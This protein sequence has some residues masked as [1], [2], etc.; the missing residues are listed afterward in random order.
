MPIANAGEHPRTHAMFIEKTLLLLIA[1]LAPQLAHCA[2]PKILPNAAQPAVDQPA[3]DA[4]VA[5]KD[6]IAKTTDNICGLRDVNQ[7]SNPAIVDFKA[8][9]DATPEMKKAR[10]DKV[11]LT[12]PEGIKL[13]NAAVNR[14]T[15]ACETVRVANGY[16]SVWKTIRHKDGR[17]VTDIS[18]LVKAQY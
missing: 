18:E 13:S 2:L 6:W 14:V 5:S 16:C 1:S 15:T 12:T 9:L 8:C 4:V 7:I 11:D 17:T 3:V 10:E